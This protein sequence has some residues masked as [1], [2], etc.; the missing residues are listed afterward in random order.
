MKK[1]YLILEDGT[2]FVGKSMGI[3]GTAIGEVC[4]NTC[5]IGYQEQLTNPNNNG[6][7]LTQTFPIIGNY[8]I[9][10]DG[11][12]T[13]K[14]FA[15]GYIVREICDAPSNYKSK[16]DLNSFLIQNNV[17]GICDVD[18]RSLTRHIRENGALNGAITTDEINDK[19][20]SQIKSFKI[21]K[22]VPQI[23]QKSVTGNKTVAIV[24]LGV[25]STLLNA[26]TSRGIGY[27]IVDESFSDF[28]KFDG[29][30]ISDGGGNPTD[31]ALNIN[32]DK[33]ILAIGLG[34]LAYLNSKGA[35]ITKQLY[36][37]RGA[38]QPVK[39][40]LNER[41]YITSQNHGYIVENLP[42]EYKVTYINANDKTIEGA[43]GNNETLIAFMP[44]NDKSMVSTSY[45]YDEFIQ[46]VLER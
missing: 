17:I 39:N 34:M 40:L 8:G 9:N 35:T 15:N 28:D 30:V 43:K 29:I 12:V 2:T 45:I 46:S 6:L 24:N 5:C 11:N 25:T 10:D 32:T 22:Q 44:D 23:K 37:H 36:G 3:E 27:E 21:E 1:A 38:N 31:F 14:I 42:N 16:G 33:P 19:L 20:I 18:T 4:F 41:T 7:L 13:D 26:L